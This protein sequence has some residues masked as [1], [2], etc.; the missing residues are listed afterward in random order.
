VTGHGAIEKG[1]ISV[2]FLRRA[3]P[4]LLEQRSPG[5]LGGIRGGCQQVEQQTPLLAKLGR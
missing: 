2:G 5:V 1:L 3:I 4:K